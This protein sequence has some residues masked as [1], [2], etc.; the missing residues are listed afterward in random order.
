MMEARRQP[1]GSTLSITEENRHEEEEQQLKSPNS[2][3]STSSPS[4]E[5]SFALT[6]P[7][8]TT[9]RAVDLSPA[10]DIFFYGHLLP[11]HLF[12]RLPVS[13]RSS[14][15]SSDGFTLPGTEFVQNQT[16][17]AEPVRPPKSKSFA[18]FKRWRKRSEAGKPVEAEKKR[19]QRQ[20]RFELSR[21][22]K[23][24]ARLVRPLLTFRE[25]RRNKRNQFKPQP[26]SYSGNLGFRGRQEVVRGRGGE[27]AS[28]PA[29]IRT[30]PVNS[31]ILLTTAKRVPSP[32]ADST[33]EELQ[34]AIQA[35]IAHCKNSIA[36]DKHC[37]L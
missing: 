7:F 17:F 6:V 13:P 1:G 36:A 21:L 33:M 27:Y 19:T 37:K 26:I 35:A 22:L 10:D 23:M 16:S 18:F 29:S 9:Q 2:V 11:L 24:Y 15:D 32:V 14:T 31:G 4:H 5:F 25:G 34:S 30:S 20:F 8:S 28:A 3:S 12:P